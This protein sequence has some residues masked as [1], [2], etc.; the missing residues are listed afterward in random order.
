MGASRRAT[1]TPT[2]PNQHPERLSISQAHPGREALVSLRGLPGVEGRV[3]RDITRATARDQRDS[4]VH[5]SGAGVGR[6]QHGGPDVTHEVQGPPTPAP[7]R[8]PRRNWRGVPP[9]GPSFPHPAGRA[10][11][12]ASTHHGHEPRERA[13]RLHLGSGTPVRPEAR[14]PRTSTRERCA[15]SSAKGPAHPG[16]PR[17]QRAWLTWGAAAPGWAPTPGGRQKPP[18]TPAA[19]RKATGSSLPE[20]LATP[21]PNCQEQA[22]SL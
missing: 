12:P 13:R 21:H 7:P 15:L 8:P 4:H 6:H 19:R 20:E 16:A 14:G 10:R 3:H 1:P 22:Q 5:S 9:R 18:L 11:P 17:R 2:R